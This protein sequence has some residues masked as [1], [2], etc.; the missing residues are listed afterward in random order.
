VERTA[1]GLEEQELG[2]GVEYMTLNPRAQAGANAHELPHPPS[3]H[4]S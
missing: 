4:E 3:I 1:S 2:T